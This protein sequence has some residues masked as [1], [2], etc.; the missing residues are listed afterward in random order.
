ME[1][2]DDI[3]ARLKAL[4]AKPGF[5]KPVLWLGIP[6]VLGIAFATLYRGFPL[7]DR[8]TLVCCIGF[9]LLAGLWG[10]VR[11]AATEPQQRKTVSRRR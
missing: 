4:W 1:N 9:L 3:K 10:V 7:W 5:R 11:V 2:T 8:N 6:I